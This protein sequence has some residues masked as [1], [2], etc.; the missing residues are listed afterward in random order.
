MTVGHVFYY[1]EN[2]GDNFRNYALL[3]HWNEL[4]LDHVPSE[5]TDSCLTRTSVWKEIHINVR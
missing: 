3:K 4:S 5:E 2:K 1:L